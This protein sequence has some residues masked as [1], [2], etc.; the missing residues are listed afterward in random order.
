MLDDK[1]IK[2]WYAA[3]VKERMNEYDLKPYHVAYKCQ[4]RHSAVSNYLSGNVWPNPWSLVLMAELFECC[5]DDLLGYDTPDDISI[6]ERYQA[7]RM[8]ANKEEYA[9]CFAE[10]L[11][12]YLNNNDISMEDLSKRSGFTVK[13]LKTWTNDFNPKLPATSRV[14]EICSALDCTPSELLGY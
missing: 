14:L 5:V 8:F 1:N 11:V 10:R 12:G 9:H 4:I 6:F 13:T 2:A 7:S 3:E